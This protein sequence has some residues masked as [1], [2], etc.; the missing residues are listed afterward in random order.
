MGNVDT[1][2]GEGLF[3]YAPLFASASANSFLMMSM[4]AWT[5]WWRFCVESI[6]FGVLLPLYLIMIM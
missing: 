1:W 3:F 5:L 2:C 6:I 4:W